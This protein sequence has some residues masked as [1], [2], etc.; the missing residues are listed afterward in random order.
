MEGERGKRGM[1][2]EWEGE[3]WS[4]IMVT[5][6]MYCECIIPGAHQAA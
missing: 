6:I 1:E 4:D 5:Y 3:G 2:G